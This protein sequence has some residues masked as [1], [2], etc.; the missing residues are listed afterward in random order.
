MFPSLC[1]CC[2][3]VVKYFNIMYE[4]NIPTMIPALRVHI[5]IQLKF[6][7]HRT[8]CIH[9]YLWHRLSSSCWCFCCLPQLSSKLFSILSHRWNWVCWQAWFVYARDYP[10]SAK[11]YIPTYT[12]QRVE[13][14]H[15]RQK[16]IWLHFSS[17]SVRHPWKSCFL[18]SW[19]RGIL[20]R[21]IAFS[22]NPV[23]SNSN[24]L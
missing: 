20:M 23:L 8:P 13:W 22:Y 24:I 3:W 7:P 16:T 1:I 9:T 18:H 5:Q 17:L 15:S 14:R 19:R 10:S 2:T 12:I 11:L 21:E 6:A 4:Y